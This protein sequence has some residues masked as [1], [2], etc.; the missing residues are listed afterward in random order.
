MGARRPLPASPSWP[1]LT[2]ARAHP[3]DPRPLGTWTVHP[4]SAAPLLHP[5]HLGLKLSLSLLLDVIYSG[6]AESDKLR[7]FPLDRGSGRGERESRG[8][9]QGPQDG[10]GSWLCGTPTS[11]VSSEFLPLFLWPALGPGSSPG[12]LGHSDP[13]S[14][15]SPDF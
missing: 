4:F 10:A 15:F 13:F 5:Q 3:R 8:A 6:S 11:R 14:G 12:V 2:A 1:L 7:F 9:G